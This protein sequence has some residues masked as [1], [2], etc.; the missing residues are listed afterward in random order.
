MP[1]SADYSRRLSIITLA[2]QTP[3]G[4]KFDRVL[5]SHD[6][7]KVALAKAEL[8]SLPIRK[9]KALVIRSG[10]K[11]ISAGP[12]NIGTEL[13]TEEMGPIDMSRAFHFRISRW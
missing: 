7:G 10:L 12:M 8:A 2:A 1:F 6:S 9:N 11:R 13:L 3:R 5:K 4:S